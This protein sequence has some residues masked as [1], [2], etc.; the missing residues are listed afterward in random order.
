MTRFLPARPVTYTFVVTNTGDTTLFDIS[1]DDDVLGHIGD[2]PML[3]AG[4]SQTFT[5]SFT[6]GD[7]PVTN[8]ATASGEDVLGETVTASDTAF[9]DVVSG[10][11]GRVGPAAADGSRPAAVPP[12]GPRSR[13]PRSGSGP[14]S[15]QPWP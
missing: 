1:V 8:T 15:R 9:V 4:A 5:A 10:G 7:S 14:R 12:V 11:G 6:V 13:D 3:S 2:I